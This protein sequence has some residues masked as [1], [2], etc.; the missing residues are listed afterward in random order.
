MASQELQW[1]LVRNYNSFQIGKDG[2]TF[3]AEPNNLTNISSFKYSGLINDKVVG[4]EGGA[5]NGKQVVDLSVKG[6]GANKPKSAF[7]KFRLSTQY[8]KN[9]G[10]STS[11]MVSNSQYDSK[12]KKKSNTSAIGKAT[13][14]YR[15][16]L[17]KAAVARYLKL[18]KSLKVQS[19]DALLNKIKANVLKSMRNPPQ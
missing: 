13:Q 6:R 1:L 9:S 12:A 15:S 14:F 17:S 4:V 19:D 16:D 2:I 18:R 8:T 3:S 10:D 5:S 7:A 11:V